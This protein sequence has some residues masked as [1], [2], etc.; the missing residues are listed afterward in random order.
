VGSNE[1]VF[2]KCKKRGGFRL[3]DLDCYKAGKGLKA[4]FRAAVLAGR[5][6]DC[7]CLF[8]VFGN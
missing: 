6:I 4:H 1:L 8:L 3:A 7:K 5:Q 2:G